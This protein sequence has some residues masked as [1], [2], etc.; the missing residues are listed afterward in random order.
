MKGCLGRSGLLSIY[1]PVLFCLLSF[2][3][4]WAQQLMA[5]MPFQAISYIPSMIITESFQGAAV[6]DGLF[7]QAAWCVLLWFPIALLW[8]V[9]KK[10]LVV[11][12]G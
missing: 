3:P 12:G 2:Y 1:F 9:A 6:S 8:R 5:Y 4:D 7:T 11:Q 10:R